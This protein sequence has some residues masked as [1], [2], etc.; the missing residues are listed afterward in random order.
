LG[1]HPPAAWLTVARSQRFVVG[2]AVPVARDM[3][4]KQPVERWFTALCT[5]P[6]LLIT[7]AYV[8]WGCA[9]VALARWP[10]PNLDDPKRLAT[11]PIHVAFQ[12]MAFSALAAIPVVVVI[13][14][15]NWQTI[16][17]DRRYSVRV[18]AFVLGLV[19]V[20]ALSRYDPGDVW[21]WLAD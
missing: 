17:L 16:F 18:G 15:K 14:A 11:A 1:L 2:R 8:E 12:A 3:I 9:F 6:W 20:G 13:V 5:V 4:N 21:K 19:V 7:M 10:R